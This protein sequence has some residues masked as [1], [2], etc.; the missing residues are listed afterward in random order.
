LSPDGSLGEEREFR[1]G[2]DLESGVERQVNVAP[3]RVLT[4]AGLNC[5]SNDVN[6]IRGDSA[7]L[8]RTS[9]SRR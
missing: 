6:G 7:R 1:G 8:I 3:G 4:S 9:A 5:M 2:I